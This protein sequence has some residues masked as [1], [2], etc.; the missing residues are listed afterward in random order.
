M[1][2]RCGISPGLEALGVRPDIPHVRCDECGARIDAVTRD[3]NMT[4]WLRKGTAPKGWQMIRNDAR[5]GRHRT[6]YCPRCRTDGKGAARPEGTE[7]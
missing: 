6:D 3:G 2:Y 5:G 1:T 7:R 4:A